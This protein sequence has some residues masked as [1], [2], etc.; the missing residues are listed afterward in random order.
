MLLWRCG[1]D[2]GRCSDADADR[3]ESFLL[4]D[5]VRVFVRIRPALEANSETA[6][7]TQLIGSDLQK[8]SVQRAYAPLTN[9]LSI[10]TIVF[11]SKFSVWPFSNSWDS[12]EMV[13]LPRANS[14]LTASFPRTRR[15]RMCIMKLFAP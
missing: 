14:C 15:S 3:T 9:A 12:A 7:A 11:S 1:F 6:G 13:T 4:A 10:E 5:R 8:I 2:L